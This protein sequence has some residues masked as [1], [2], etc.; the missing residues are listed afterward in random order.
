MSVRRID[1]HCSDDYGTDLVL[2]DCEDAIEH[3][4][5]VTQTVTFADRHD[6]GIPAGAIPLP[7]RLMGGRCIVTET[8][9]CRT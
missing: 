8:L 3:I 7:W 9:Y 6:E 4:D 2:G 5:P 1:V